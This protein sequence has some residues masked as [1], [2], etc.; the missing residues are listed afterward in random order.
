MYFRE[1]FTELATDPEKLDRLADGFNQLYDQGVIDEFADQH[2]TFFLDGIHWSPQFLP[3]HRHFLLKIEQR[4][5]SID[6]RIVLPYWDWTRADSRSLELGP[7]LSFFGGRANAGGRFDHWSYTRLQ[8]EPTIN[9]LPTHADIANELRNKANF[10]EYRAIECGSHFPA[11]TWTGLGH[12]MGGGRSPADPLF[13]LHH[14]NLDRLWAIWQLNNPGVEQYSVARRPTCDLAS[15]ASVD[16]D[17]PM[18]GGATPASMLDHTA[19]GY[20]YPLD[21]ELEKEVDGDPDFAEF[22]SGDLAPVSLKTP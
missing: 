3:W 18:V 20:G 10:T 11:H 15:V 21:D 17:S 14:C 9:T 5:Q 6:S 2:A 16:L 1:N 13:F 19:L 8:P 22:L 12:T 4:L 7:W